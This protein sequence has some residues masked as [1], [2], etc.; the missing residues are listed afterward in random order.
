MQW[1]KTPPVAPEKGFNSEFYWFYDSMDKTTTVVEV[2]PKR[3]LK[4]YHGYWWTTPISRPPEKPPREAR[5]NGERPEDLK[6]RSTRQTRASDSG[7]TGEVSCR[8]SSEDIDGLDND[9]PKV[10]A[11]KKRR[12]RPPKGSKE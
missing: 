2:W 4:H 5:S 10:D 6:G 11:G 1:S 12:G 9:L 3:W 8:I 7:E